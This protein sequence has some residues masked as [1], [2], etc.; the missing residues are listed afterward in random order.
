MGRLAPIGP[1]KFEAKRPRAGPLQPWLMDQKYQLAMALDLNTPLG[2]RP[3][4]FRC[5]DVFVLCM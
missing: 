5:V 1:T 3:G 2:Q 4:E